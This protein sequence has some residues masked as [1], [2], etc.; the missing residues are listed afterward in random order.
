VR[1]VLVE[2]APTFL[3]EA[4]DPEQLAFD[5]ESLRTFAK[6]VLLTVG[7]QS[8]AL[9]APVVAK[10]AP[11]LPRAEVT[12]VAGA[13]HVPHATH[14]ESYADVIAAFVAQHDDGSRRGPR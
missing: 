5:L 8:P 6:P 2:N 14:P 3:D 9:F 4:L 11:A 13:G 12:T 1:R 7:D 10:L